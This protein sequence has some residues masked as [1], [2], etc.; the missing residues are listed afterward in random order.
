MQSCSP[1]VPHELHTQCPAHPLLGVT[2]RAAKAW[3]LAFPQTCFSHILPGL[4]KGHVLSISAGQMPKPWSCPYSFLSE[5]KSV[6]SFCQVYSKDAQILATPRP[7]DWSHHH[8]S[9]ELM[10]KAGAR[11]LLLPAP[12]VLQS[13]S[14][15]TIV[16]TQNHPSPI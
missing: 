8:L 5:T 4:L 15:Q 10:Q 14:C 1:N 6:G 7:H 3:L 2:P 9:P 12:H 11:S 16:S 13:S